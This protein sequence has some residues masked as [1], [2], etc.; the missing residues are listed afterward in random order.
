MCDLR[1]KNVALGVSDM[2]AKVKEATGGEAW[3]PSG[4][5]LNELALATS[6]E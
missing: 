2:E 3:G 4:T 5:V 6:D 1:S